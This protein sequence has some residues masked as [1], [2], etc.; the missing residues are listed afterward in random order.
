MKSTLNDLKALFTVA[1][2]NG[3]KKISKHQAS[4]KNH[5]HTG[6]NPSKG[7]MKDFAKG[8]KPLGVSKKLFK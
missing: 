3:N 2:V 4:K 1:K 5:I 8:I 7:Q 6:W